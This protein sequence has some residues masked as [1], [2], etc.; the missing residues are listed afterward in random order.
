MNGGCFFEVTFAAR[1]STQCEG[2]ADVLV[3]S[4]AMGCFR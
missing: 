4:E 3:C 1:D 2:A